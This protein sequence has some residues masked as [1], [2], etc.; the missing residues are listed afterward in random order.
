VGFSNKVK[1][2]LSQHQLLVPVVMVRLRVYFNQL[3]G[4]RSPTP[5]KAEDR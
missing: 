1:E 4:K 3:F 5:R 2:L